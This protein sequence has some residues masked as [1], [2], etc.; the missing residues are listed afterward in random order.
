M[1]RYCF[2]NVKYETISTSSSIKG[3]IK[4]L[5]PKPTVIQ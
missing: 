2:N 1:L 4:A 5:F 3:Q